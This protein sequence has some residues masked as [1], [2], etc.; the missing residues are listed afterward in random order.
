MKFH[1]RSTKKVS[2][3]STEKLNF[4]I[5]QLQCRKSQILIFKRMLISS[6]RSDC[7]IQLFLIVFQMALDAKA[8]KEEVLD[9]DMYESNARRVKGKWK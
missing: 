9:K 1:F 7:V 8:I 6:P 2:F 4:L 5:R 3:L